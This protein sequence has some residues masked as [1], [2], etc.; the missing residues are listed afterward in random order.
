[1]KKQRRGLFILSFILGLLCNVICF[2]INYVWEQILT[3]NLLITEISI[4]GFSL[5]VITSLVDTFFEDYRNL[6]VLLLDILF[7]L[8]AI[9]ICIFKSPI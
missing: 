3:I 2:H 9:S 7:I 8:S 5:L 1:M 6:S 4:I